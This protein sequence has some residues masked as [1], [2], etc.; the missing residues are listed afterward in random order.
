MRACAGSSPLT[1]GTPLNLCLGRLPIRFIPAYAG[2]S[3]RSKASI[4]VGAVHPRLRGELKAKLYPELCQDGSSPLTRGTLYRGGGGVFPYP[5]HPR[6]RG[7]LSI[8]L[9]R[10]VPI[11]RFIPAYAGNSNR[12]AKERELQVG[13]SPLTRGTHG[14]IPNSRAIAAVHPRLRGELNIRTADAMAPTGSSPLT[15]GTLDGRK[16]DPSL[17]RF[18]PAYAGNSQVVLPN[19]TQAT[20]HP[21]LR[22]ELIKART[23]LKDRIGSSPLTRGTRISI[24]SV[25]TLRR[26][27]PAYAGN[28]VIQALCSTSCAVHPRLRGEL[29]SF[30]RHCTTEDGSSPLTRGTR[31]QLRRNLTC[32]RFIPAYAGNSLAIHSVASAPSVHPRL[33]GELFKLSDNLAW[34]FGSSPLTRGTRLSAS[35]SY[36]SCRFIPAYA[37]NSP[38]PD[39]TAI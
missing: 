15:R 11:C 10:V 12:T 34:C 33:R 30:I 3:S 36:N 27:I 6:L 13:S 21:R 26:F 17:P 25:M 28:S 18:I 20:V 2:N 1:R 19:I 14:V 39:A 9:A 31:G 7:E 37:G 29:L 32:V 16:G 23:I 8:A 22:G 24:C 35:F 5:V 4:F 38:C